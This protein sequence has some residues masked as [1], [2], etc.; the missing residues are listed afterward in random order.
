[1]PVSIETTIDRNKHNYRNAFAPV[2]NLNK[3]IFTGDLT[4]VRNT[5]SYSGWGFALKLI[6]ISP[7][8]IETEIILLYIFFSEIVRNSI[9][10]TINIC[11]GNPKHLN[12]IYTHRSNISV[13]NK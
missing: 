3:C 8:S 1:M 12:N 10:M 7:K 9:C 11:I 2:H 6:W 13:H 5:A 4:K